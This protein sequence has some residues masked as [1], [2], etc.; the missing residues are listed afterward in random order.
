MDGAPA[1]SISD[2]HPSGWIQM[3]IFTKWFHHFVHFIKP[4]AGNP[5]LLIVDGHYFPPKVSLLWRSGGAC[6]II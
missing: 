1:G 5:V 6:V 2:C 3:N 4:S